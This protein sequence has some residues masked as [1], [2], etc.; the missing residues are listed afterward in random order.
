MIGPVG[1]EHVTTARMPSRTTPTT[2]IRSVVSKERPRLASSSRS[3]SLAAGFIVFMFT[4]CVTKKMKDEFTHVKSHVTNAQTSLTKALEVLRDEEVA[5]AQD[6]SRKLREE[7]TK[8]QTELAIVKTEAEGCKVERYSPFPR[9][10][11]KFR[12]ELSSVF[13]GATAMLQ[14]NLPPELATN[15]QATPG[16]KVAVVMQSAEGADWVLSIE[17]LNALRAYVIMVLKVS[18]G[19]ISIQVI[20]QSPQGSTKIFRHIEM[21]FE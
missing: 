1:P 2:V 9:G 18:P 11:V 13:Q 17:R 12:Y 10:P 7:L 15:L 16:A 14:P 3:H 20:P 8:T 4:G 21:W 6:E 5:A 19:R